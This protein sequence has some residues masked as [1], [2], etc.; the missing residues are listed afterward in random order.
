MPDNTLPAASYGEALRIAA[1]RLR[2]AGVASPEWDARI[3]AAHLIHTGHMDIPLAE[4]PMPGFEVAFGAMVARRQAREPLQHIL[5]TAWFGPLELSVGP[6]V[7]IPR[8]ETEVLADWAVRQLKD[9]PTPRVV[10][11]CTGSGAL[12]LYIAHYRPDAQVSAVEISPEAAAYTERNIAV[13]AAERNNAARAAERNNAACGDAVELVLGD[14]TSPRLL[15]SVSGKVDLIVSNPPYVPRTEE[16]SPEVYQDPDM[17]VF[18]GA[19]GMEVIEAM[20]PTLARLLKPGG[21]VGIEHD[22]ETSALVQDALRRS[23]D[24]QEIAVLRDLTGTA[25]FVT[26]TRGVQ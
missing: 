24:F 18:A 7:F 22:D 9:A 23:G 2:A 13:C 4:A 1:E 16:L 17:A 6:G 25:R 12:A 21:K 5:G 11:L 14:A 26:A 19:D 15:T 8:P 10:D 20:V 3:M